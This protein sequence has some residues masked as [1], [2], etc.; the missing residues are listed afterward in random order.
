MSQAI[1]EIKEKIDDY[2]QTIIAI[3]GFMN[4]YLYDSKQD[5]VI[6]FQG[7]RLNPIESKDQEEYVTPDIGILLPDNLG[8]LGEVKH[9]FPKDKNLWNG[10]FDQILKYDQDFKWWP[11]KTETVSNHEVAL[12][13]HQSRA[14]AVG[15]FYREKQITNEIEFNNQFTIVEYSRTS[16]GKEYFFFRIEEGKLNDVNVDE[17]LQEGKLVPMDILLQQYAAIKIYDS[18]PEV[19]YL[20]NLIWTNIVLDRASDDERFISLAKNQKLDVKFTVEE[21]VTNLRENFSFL[22][23]NHDNNNHQPLMPKTKWV[24]EACERFVSWKEAKWADD[25]KSTILFHAHKKYSDTL[26]SFIEKYV[27]EGNLDYPTLFSEQ[28]LE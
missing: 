1:K 18:K 6:T 10:I 13:T 9:S 22:Q 14:R 7:R 24:K 20:M 23:L 27:G 2:S 3:V 16:Q 11:T 19:P 8:L 12:L 4:F 5:P 17:L 21:I 25:V 15:N 28:D 26:N